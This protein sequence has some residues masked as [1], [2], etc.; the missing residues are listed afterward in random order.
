[1]KRLAPDAAAAVILALVLAFFYWGF[2]RG[3]YFMW[4]D[5]LAE[6]YPGVNYFARTIHEGRFPLWFRGVRDGSP[7]YSDLQLAVFYPPQWLLIP[8]VQNGR[9]PFL[10]YQQ[11]MV[12]HYLVGGLFMYAFLKR[13]KL[14]PM[15]ALAGALV[16][17]LSGFACLRIVNF[18]MFQVYVWLPLQ[19]Y[20]V[21][22]FTSGE[23]RWA[24]LGLVGAMLMSLLAGSPQVTLYSWYLVIAYWLYCC[25]SG[26]HRK[27][28]R[29]GETI[30]HVAKRD[31]P[32][33]IGTFV[34]VLGLSAVMVL[35]S[36]ENWERSVRTRQ[37]FEQ[38]TDHS[39]PYSQLLT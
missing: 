32:K 27:S 38:L 13:L 15:A 33:L 20:C 14:S 35:P 26:R 31:L 19:L 5:T 11:Y 29:W 25:W 1:M 2:V 9:L 30:R 4:D 6:F 17:C 16:F 10:A 39:L 3:R 18:V 21:H 23:D 28:A 8:F 24:W 22:R 12:L 37:S 7:F 36:A 34:L